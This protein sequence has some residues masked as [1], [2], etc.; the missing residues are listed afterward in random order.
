MPGARVSLELLI[1]LG[2][3]AV[4]VSVAAVAL[5]RDRR[6]RIH[7]ARAWTVGGVLGAYCVGRG[8]AELITVHYNDPASYRLDWG[9]PSLAGVLAVH[10]GPGL[11]VLVA[12]AVYIWRRSLHRSATGR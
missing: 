9:G 5:P 12:A 7:R 4:I 3:V 8:A 11:A 1:L 2:A 6:R 10:A